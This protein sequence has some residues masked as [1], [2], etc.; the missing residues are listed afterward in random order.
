MTQSVVCIRTPLISPQLHDILVLT[1]DTKDD[2]SVK[3]MAELLRRGATMLA[4]AC[5]QCGS[6]LFKVGDDIYCATCDRRIVYA[7]SDEEV[8]TQAV[9]TLLPE[10]RETLIGKLKALNELVDSETDIES[11]TK[12]ANLMVLLLQSLHRLE[13]MKGQ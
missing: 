12:L 11:L 8:E 3:K 6:P 5:P 2:T 1:M 10:L 7:D 13:N 4:D 9:M